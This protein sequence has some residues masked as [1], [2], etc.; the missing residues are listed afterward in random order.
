[1]RPR[2]FLALALLALPAA[3]AAQ[4]LPSKPPAPMPLKPAAFP[5]FQE[6]VLPNGLRVVVVESRKQPVFSATLAIPA[7]SFHD[8]A[9]KEGLANMLAGLLTKGAGSRS[10]DE[11]AAAIEG[12]GGSLT[13]SADQ[14]YLRVR[15]G[16]LVTSAELAFGLMADAVARPT[17]PEKEVELLRTQALSAL[18]L[19][20]ANPNQLAE[21]F[22]ARELYG[23]HPY[24]RRPV[25]ASLKAITRDDLAA[26]HKARVVPAGA[27]LV[28]AGDL[29]LAQVRDLAGKAFGGWAGK[30]PVAAAAPALP[31]RGKTGI[32]LVHRPGSV[33]SVVTL[34]NLAYA[35]GSPLEYPAEVANKVLGGGSD[36]RL[37]MILREQKSWSYGAYSGINEQRRAVAFGASTQVRTEATDSALAEMLAQ[38]RRMRAELVPAA[39]LDAAKG[40]LVGSF[41]LQVETAEQVAAK[42]ADAKLYA[43]PA[44]YLAT[45]RT[46]IAAVTAA[47][48]QAAARSVMRPDSMLVLV[49]GDGAAL[50]DRLAKIAPVRLVDAD[51]KPLT[52]ADLAPKA[53][54]L[55]LDLSRLVA[56]S[57]SFAIVVQG[58]PFGWQKSALER[59]ADGFTYVEESQ[60]ATVLQQRTEVRLSAQGATL[61][62]QQAGKAQGQD[63]KVEATYAG[64]R[65]KGSATTPSPQGMKSVTYDTTVVAGTIDDNAVQALLPALAWGPGARHVLNVFASGQGTARTMTLQVSGA[66]QVTVP[67]G[68]FDTW[69]VDVSGGQQPLVFYVTKAAPHRLV[70]IALAAAPVEIQLVK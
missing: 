42:V 49:V 29:S 13:A 31:K 54:A 46:R 10:A 43:K 33:Q 52:P 22:V 53:A 18:R 67:A 35:P 20:Q 21:R 50:H 26:F 30:P 4:A 36:A 24:G 28:V 12:A 5:P 45:Y 59:T 69:K 64:G 17:L 37:F 8:P 57:D 48:A 19:E 23:S 32:V 6:A 3:V 61:S 9:G 1:M 39:E 7:G 14:D 47:Q 63:T 65:V 11:I 51:G 58:N 40:N 34:A 68:A 70:K 38:V 41:P 2:P 55:A 56:R 62:V 60:L 25:E 27:L 44:D 66:E 16:G 15:V